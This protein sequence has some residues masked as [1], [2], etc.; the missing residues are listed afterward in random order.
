[1]RVASGDRQA[2][3]L[4]AAPP[5]GREPYWRCRGGSRSGT[6]R[7]CRR[8]RRTTSQSYR[9]RLPVTRSG[10][11]ES[12]PSGRPGP[13]ASSRESRSWSLQP[14]FGQVSVT[15]VSRPRNQISPLG[16]AWRAFCYLSRANAGTN[17][18]RVR[19]ASPRSSLTY[20]RRNSG[21]S[22]PQVA[23][24]I[25]CAFVRAR[26]APRAQPFVSTH[27]GPTGTSNRL[28]ST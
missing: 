23:T 25:T 11:R 3:R 15:L 8:D 24:R 4:I 1:M 13:P 7:G 22:L 6:T 17:C 26:R 20:Q 10:T 14:G 27:V 12:L 2:R 16:S 21:R 28:R 9:C 18:R 19:R 5:G